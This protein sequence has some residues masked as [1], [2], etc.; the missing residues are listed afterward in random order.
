MKHLSRKVWRYVSSNWICVNV[1]VWLCFP[2]GCI[3]VQNHLLVSSVTRHSEPRVIKRLTCY[4]IP[5]KMVEPQKKGFQGG[6]WWDR[7][8]LFLC[9]QKLLCRNQLLSQ[10]M[11]SFYSTCTSAP[12]VQNIWYNF[13]VIKWAVPHVSYYDNIFCVLCSHMRSA[14]LSVYVYSL[15]ITLPFESLLI[16]HPSVISL[17]TW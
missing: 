13:Y 4:L 3:Q 2:P 10:I 17:T 5:K 16:S 9:Y 7:N 8:P 12:T 6:K 1:S 11:V 15:W 14:L